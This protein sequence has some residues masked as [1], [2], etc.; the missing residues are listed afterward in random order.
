MAGLFRCRR[1]VCVRYISA[2]V[3]MPMFR[4]RDALVFVVA[5]AALILPF[6]LWA[7][8][9]CYEYRPSS[10]VAWYPTPDGATEES[11][12]TVTASCNPGPCACGSGAAVYPR[13]NPSVTG[14]SEPIGS[15]S[16]FQSRITLTWTSDQGGSMSR[17]CVIGMTRRGVDCPIAD[18]STYDG[19]GAHGFYKF[20]DRS[21]LSEEMC[22]SGSNCVATRASMQ[23][24]GDAD[25]IASYTISSRIACGSGEPTQEED[26]NKGEG[27]ACVGDFCTSEPG[28]KSCGFYNDNYVCLDRTPKDGCQALADGSRI[29]AQQAPTPPVPDNGTPGV[30]AGP[31]DELQ[32]QQGDTVTNYHYYSAGTVGGSARDPGPGPNPAAPVDGEGDEGAGSGLHC[33]P[34]TDEFCSEEGAYGEGDDPRSGWQC[35]ADGAGLSSA[36][37]ACFAAAGQGLWNTLVA[38]S[39]L[40]QVAT[41]TAAAF[42]A[43]SGVCPSGD[44]SL[45]WI[46]L[47]V[48]FWEVPCQFLDQFASFMG[49]LF[50]LMWSLIGLRIL[51]TIPGGE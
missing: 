33:D 39:S 50:L 19:P 23:C 10:G 18:C 21:S 6:A 24:S 3:A 14:V 5:I 35:W 41:D 7:Q 45:D 51:L 26:L 9:Q 28:D 34:S 48:D 4:L 37:S 31:D 8:Q 11:A 36:V 12:D 43:G 27:E 46:G 1:T 42:T 32:T 16:G 38:E 29:C 20:G 30:P 2:V 40:L 49:P 22:H 44:V 17:E 13:N 25:C 47:S 15:G